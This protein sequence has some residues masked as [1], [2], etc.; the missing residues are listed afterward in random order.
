MAKTTILLTD[1]FEEWVDGTNVISAAVGDLTLLTTSE[2]SDLVGAINS[3]KTEQMDSDEFVKISGSG[4][5]GNLLFGD[6]IEAHFGT[7]T[8]LKIHHDGSNSYIS[9]SGTG[10]LIIKSSLFRVRSTTNEEMI[11]AT[12][13][14]GVNLYFNN[15][16]KLVTQNTGVSITGDI[17][18]SGTV[19]GRDI[20]A[21]GSD[22][23]SNSTAIGT[24]S[25]K[26]STIE[27]SADKT[28]TDNVGA[29]GALMKTGGTMTGE[30]VLD[31]VK[32][33]QYAL[34]GTVIDP[35]NG[36]MQY[37]T[38]A[39]NTTFTESID[40]GQG[41]LLALDDGD[42]AYTVTWPTMT[43]VTDGA[44]A[45]TLE[46]SGYTFISLWDM[47]GTLYGAKINA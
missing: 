18:V 24:I 1:T 30:L 44:T 8:D 37:K 43:W 47:N 10:D 7:G 22:I 12:Q 6:G 28:D 36:G 46:T 16:N 19:D 42:S 4:L 26:L 35:A 13:N 20:A 33:T 34:S 32:E 11:A 25:T 39:S 31:E 21:D 2:D 17:T 40:S 5:T 9:D 15:N 41:V 14:G 23:D 3:L 38:L 27:T 45:P 29:A